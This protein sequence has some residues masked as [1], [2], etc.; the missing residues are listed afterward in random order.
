MILILVKY[1]DG[2]PFLNLVET[3]I[4]DGS[5]LSMKA[6][7]TNPMLIHV[8]V[9]DDCWEDVLGVVQAGESI[10]DISLF[11][12]MRFVCRFCV[13]LLCDSFRRID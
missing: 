10:K 12:P 8:A 9:I 2:L 3:S 13:G 7:L 11:V 5:L 6:V 4:F 1:R